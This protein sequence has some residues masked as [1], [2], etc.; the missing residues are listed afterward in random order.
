MTP[1]FIGRK[2]AHTNAEVSTSMIY[3]PSGDGDRAGLEAIQSDD[4][5]LFLGVSQDHGTRRVALMIRQGA[6]DPRQGRVVA[7]SPLPPRTPAVRLDLKISGGRLAAAYAIGKG[8][9]RPLVSGFDATFLSTKT[10]GGFVGTVIGLANETE[11]D[12]PPAP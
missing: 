6:G 5:Y 7:E 10:A 9:W 11:A 8:A 1:A 3:S 4:S 2:Q 12:K